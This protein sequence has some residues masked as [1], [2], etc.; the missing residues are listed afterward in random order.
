LELPVHLNQQQTTNKTTS[1]TLISN[2]EMSS[3]FKVLIPIIL[4]KKHFTLF[5]AVYQVASVED[6]EII[7]NRSVT[8]LEKITIKEE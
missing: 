3:T 8:H 4:L 6:S 1:S 2:K 5:K 7:I